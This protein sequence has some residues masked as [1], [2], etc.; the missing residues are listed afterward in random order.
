MNIHGLV[1]VIVGIAIGIASHF[2]PNMEFFYI[3]AGGF[4][5]YGVYKIVRNVLS[6]KLLGPEPKIIGP[7]AKNEL[8]VNTISCPKCGLK[9]YSNANYCQQC[10]TK[11]K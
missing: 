1:F 6:R 3:A 9:H 10:G 5:L 2:I 8:S 4:V 11:L 7:K